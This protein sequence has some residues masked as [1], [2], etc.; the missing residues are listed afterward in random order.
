[1]SFR[2]KLHRFAIFVLII[3]WVYAAASKLIGFDDFENQMK[4]QPMPQFLQVLLIYTLPPSELLV[5][6]LLVI[7][8]TVRT[9]AYLSTVLLSTFTIYIALG[10]LKFYKYVPC[11]C[12]G[13]LRGMGWGAH[14]VLNIVFLGLTILIIQDRNG[15]EV[16]LGEVQK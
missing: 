16:S 9:G 13:I 5:A 14:L 12:G 15:R 2:L 3:L 1:M 6:A 10:L 8:S 4:Q 7:H 11:A